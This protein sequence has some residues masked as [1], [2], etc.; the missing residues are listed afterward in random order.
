MTMADA[1][2]TILSPEKA[3]A[4]YAPK[5]SVPKL[6]ASGKIEPQ[7]FATEPGKTTLGVACFGDS[8]TR[9]LGGTAS[10]YPATLDSLIPVDVLNYGVDSQFTSEIALR[11]GGLDVFVT[12]EGGSIPAS[13]S[14]G[15]TIL[16]GNPWRNGSVW[17]FPGSLAGIKGVLTKNAADAWSFAR[18]TAGTATVVLAETK[19]VSAQQAGAGVGRIIWA[20]RNNPT[21][22]RPAANVR[23]MATEA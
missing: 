23:A 4:L 22:P 5:A 11:N 12:V 19:F 2:A 13:G 20:G 8:M 15:V 3:S 21:L 18:T 1:S 17:T 10:T 9:G 6:D 7:F 14:V 16:A